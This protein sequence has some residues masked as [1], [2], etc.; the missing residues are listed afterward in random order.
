MS[1]KYLVK[2][3]AIV[4]EGRIEISDVLFFDEC[5]QKIGS[6]QPQLDFIIING[7]GK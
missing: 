2:D 5:I 3:V 7:T 6:I 1:L 4:N